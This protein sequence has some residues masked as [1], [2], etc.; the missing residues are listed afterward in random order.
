MFI[1]PS[2]RGF[3]GPHDHYLWNTVGNPLETTITAAHLVMSGVLERHPG[4]RILLAHA[5]GTVLFLRG[6]LRHSRAPHRGGARRGRRRLAAAAA[7]RHDHARP[8][9][10]ARRG[11]L[12]G[13]RQVLAGSD[14][15]FDMGDPG[16]GGHGARR[17]LGAAETELCSAATRNGCWDDRG[18]ADRRRRRGPQQ[19]DH[20]GLSR[21]R[22]LLGAR[23][24]LARHPRRRRGLRGDDRARAIGSTPARPATR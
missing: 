16:P 21:G 6:R 19:P 14:H 5:G 24:R 17:R 1:H 13:R 12:R 15:P 7:L 20:R 8:R 3:S 22:G 18:C 9:R 4:L 10:A 23:A 2:T 11:R